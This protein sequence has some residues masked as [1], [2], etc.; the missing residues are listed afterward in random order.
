MRNAA[1]LF[2]VALLLY[3]CASTPLRNP[4]LPQEVAGTWK[5]EGEPWEIT[6]TPDARVS[7]AVFRLGNVRISPNET[8]EVEMIDGQFST[9]TAG[10]CPVTYDPETREL[11]V[12]LTIDYFLARIG[13]QSVDGF[14][15]DTFT[16]IVAPD[17]KTWQT[18]WSYF[19]DYGPRLPMGPP[20][21]PVP[22]TFLKIE[23]PN[24]AG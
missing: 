20:P 13:E 6:L 4:A 1:L 23:D 5:A 2:A 21:D 14:A 19:F 9:Y 3:G 17:A 12:I 22:L 11:T 8:I 7:S 10:Q 18:N 16:G 24:A 15:Q